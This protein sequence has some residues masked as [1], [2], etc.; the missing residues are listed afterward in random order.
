MFEGMAKI[1]PDTLKAL[2][3]F[4]VETAEIEPDIVVIE[5]ETEKLMWIALAYL[6]IQG[7]NAWKAVLPYFRRHALMQQ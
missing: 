6:N 5:D 2:Y 1:A 4:P 7:E 3:L